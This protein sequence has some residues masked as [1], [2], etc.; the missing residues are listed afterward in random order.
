MMMPRKSLWFGLALA[1]VFAVLMVAS[2][3]AKPKKKRQR[4]VSGPPETLHPPLAGRAEG[5]AR[6]G[7]RRT[8]SSIVRRHIDN[9]AP[10]H[11]T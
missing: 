10:R 9:E 11:G 2:V 4:Q 5:A 7:R 3:D 1:T 6:P 8:R